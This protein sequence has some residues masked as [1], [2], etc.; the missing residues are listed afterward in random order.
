MSYNLSFITFYNWIQED[1]CGKISM[2][3]VPRPTLQ[4]NPSFFEVP[5]RL[6]RKPPDLRKCLA[7]HP[8]T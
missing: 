5:M 2:K 3:S 6:R 1:P 4:V 7:S 8:I